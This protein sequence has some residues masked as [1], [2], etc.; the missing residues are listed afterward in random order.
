MLCRASKEA[1]SRR[2][3]KIVHNG[4]NLGR[5]WFVKRALAGSYSKA[6]Q[7]EWRAEVEWRTG[8][9]EPGN[10]GTLHLVLS[11]SLAYFLCPGLNH[12]I[13]QDGHVAILTVFRV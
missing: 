5:D 8:L 6:H 1:T 9:L 12:G 3:H 11:F 13:S 10:L 7:V 4:Y 2:R